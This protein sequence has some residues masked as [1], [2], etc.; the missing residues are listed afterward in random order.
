MEGSLVERGR[1]LFTTVEGQALPVRGLTAAVA[2][3][4]PLLV[5]TF[6]GHPYTGL[7]A[8]L[9]AYLAAFRFPLGTYGE[10]A[11]SLGGV[12]TAIA[13]GSLIGGL[14]SGHHWIAVVVVPCVLFVGSAVPRLGITFGLATLFAF[15]RPTTENFVRDGLVELSGALFLGVLIMAPWPGRRLRPMRESLAAV[16]EA[17]AEALGVVTA[18]PGA[19]EWEERRTAASAAIAGARATYALYNVSNEDNRP[20][21]LLNTLSRISREIVAL[22][23]LIE[24]EAVYPLRHNADAEIRAAVAVLAA[25]LRPVAEAIETSAEG[26]WPEADAL[27][28]QRL[29][30]REAKIRRATFK[31]EED[32]VALAL[33]A[34]VRRS[35]QRIGTSID[36]AGR[37]VA[38]GITIRPSLRLP[39]APHPSSW[40]EGLASAIRTRPGL[41]LQ[42]LRVSVAGLVAMVIWVGFD[43]P[44]GYWLLITAVI[45]LQGTYGETVEMVVQR[46]GGGALGGVLAAVL[47]SLAPGKTALALIIVCMVWI[48]FT[49]RPINYTVWTFSLTPLIMM[50]LDFGA[51]VPW[52]EAVIRIF[53]NIGGGV[54]A[55][56]AARLLWPSAGVHDPSALFARLSGSLGALVRVAAAPAEEAPPLIASLQSARKATEEVADMARRLAHHPVPDLERVARLREAVAAAQRIRDH[57]I[58]V[59]GMSRAEPGEAGPVTSILNQVA[60]HLEETASALQVGDS[61]LPILDLDDLLAD[62]DEHLSS[63]AKQRRAEVI[64]GMTP[65]E[66]TPLRR[67]LLSAAAVRHAL[68]GLRA[69]VSDLTTALSR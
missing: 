48:A 60:D 55:V 9:G 4:L 59:T 29:I 23:A 58:T 26:S 67:D 41:Y 3:G 64:A 15:I 36:S 18:Q 33:V 68:R 65:E 27:A 7:V 63:L 46:I 22:R 32:L 51:P 37:I 20:Q 44:H 34:Q 54:L 40:W 57:V 50:I 17:L 28:T 30:D 49:L 21:R 47:L 24:A 12:L 66:T 2:V 1:R 39:D 25:R 13:G 14:L 53:L 11:R 16:A 43:V 42:A 5:G 6:T 69:D 56:L 52:S 8:A 19:L 10:K 62:L 38:D 35:L 45:C 61:S 31:G